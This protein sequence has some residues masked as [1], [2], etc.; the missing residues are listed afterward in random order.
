MSG[1]SVKAVVL[2]TSVQAQHILGTH[3]WRTTASVSARVFTETGGYRLEVPAGLITDFA[4]L[5]RLARVLIRTS[6]RVATA[7]VVHDYLYGRPEYT[8]RE[9]DLVLYHA[10]RD[11]AIG[12]VMSRLIY[13]G[14]R[15][16][17]WLAWRRAQRR[18]KD[19]R[20]LERQRNLL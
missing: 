18:A 13:C 20:I 7:A 14:V 10:C 15:L 17:G 9:S 2:D 19:A 6:G 11:S 16:G 4:S 5:P 3:K 1:Q 8:R 12:P